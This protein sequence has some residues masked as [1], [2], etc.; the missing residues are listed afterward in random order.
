MNQVR[1]KRTD[2]QV[3]RIC[4]GTMTFGKPVERATASRM[5]HRCI[6][7]GINFVDTADLY[8]WGLGGSML[9]EAMRG[10]T[11]QVRRCDESHGKTADGQDEAGLSRRAT[12]RAVEDS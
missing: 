9:G 5:I 12:F 10:K 8:Q 1:L 3:S 4:F 11:G 6:D 2:L 7:E